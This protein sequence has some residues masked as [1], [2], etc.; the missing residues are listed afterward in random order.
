MRLVTLA[1]ALVTVAL[2]PASAAASTHGTLV[3]RHSAPPGSMLETQF[4]RVRPPGS[5]L[6]VVTEPAQTQL[7]F[8]WSVHCFSASH[9]AS[10]G[11]SGEATVSS[12]RWTKQIRANWIKHPAYCSGSVVGSAASSPVLVRVFA[13]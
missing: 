10:G 13:Y 8:K 9:R 7:Q 5:F 11:A 3:A 1:V 4:Q 6:L 12:G 2:L